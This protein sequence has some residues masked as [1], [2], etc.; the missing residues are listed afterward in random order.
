MTIDDPCPVEIV[1][2]GINTMDHVQIESQLMAYADGELSADEAA[3]V[4]AYLTENPD[5]QAIV[6]AHTRIRATVRTNLSDEKAPAYLHARI[7]DGI[8]DT[9]PGFVATLRE[10]WGSF[11]LGPAPSL[12]L[13]TVT[14]LA[15]L[16]TL[17]SENAEAPQPAV[18]QTA[19]L[20]GQVQCIDCS[21]SHHWQVDS[22]C[23]QYGHRN[24]LVT[25]DGTMWT[26]KH[27]TEWAAHLSDTSM[28]G[29]EIT[30]KGHQN[31]SA[32]YID[33]ISFELAQSEVIENETNEEIDE[34]LAVLVSR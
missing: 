17:G 30:I 34:S 25:T 8:G 18:I 15:V 31:T 21:V 13:V 27:S 9:S 16:T 7:R 2:G 19:T 6:D 24:G 33:V 26:I 28:W 14:V 5:A 4:E 32:R 29:R 1:D 22:E 3:R 12:A 10:W 20:T 11:Q 23:D